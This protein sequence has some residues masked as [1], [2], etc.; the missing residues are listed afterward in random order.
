MAATHPSV[1]QRL[2]GWNLFAYGLTGYY[3]W[4]ANYWGDDPWSVPSGPGSS[5]RR[6][7]TLYYPHPR[8]G[9]PLPILRREACRR[10]FQDY[11][12]LVQFTEA[13]RQGKIPPQRY[14]KIAR[15]IDQYGKFG[16]WDQV[17]WGDLEDVRAQIG[18]LLSK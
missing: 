8:T 17:K 2:I 18:V 14:A 1:H 13:H 16:R 3:F 15:R 6:G 5:I 4:A 11:Q 12:Y 7:G 9:M 10:G